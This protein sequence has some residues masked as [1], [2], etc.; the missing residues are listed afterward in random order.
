LIT[1]WFGLSLV[2]SFSIHTQSAR[3]IQTRQGQLSILV[4]IPEKSTSVSG[5]YATNWFLCKFQRWRDL[6]QTISFVEP[7][8]VFLMPVWARVLPDI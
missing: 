2:Q 5:E 4:S 7:K 1:S 3:L 6:H 8:G